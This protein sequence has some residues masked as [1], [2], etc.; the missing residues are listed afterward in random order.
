MSAFTGTQE[1]FPLP[2][3][4][5]D[6]DLLA[7]W[8]LAGWIGMQSA[9]DHLRS[10]TSLFIAL[11]HEENSLSRWFLRYV[12]AA[13]IHLDQIYES[14]QFLPA[15]LPAMK[16][17]R[18]SGK[19]PDG[20][21]AFTGSARQMVE[22][23]A[24]LLSE[25]GGVELGVRHLLAAYVYRVPQGHLEQMQKWGFDRLREGSAFVRQMVAR[26][27]VEHERWEQV[28]RTTFTAPPDLNASDPSLPPKISS[29]AADTPDGEDQLNIEDDVYAL[30]ALICSTKM[31]PPLSIGLFGDWGAGKSFFIRQ[32]RRGVAFI[33][34]NARASSY[35]QKDVPFYKNVVQIEFNA[36][37]Y[38]GG[39]L[40]ASLV[41]HILENLRLTPDEDRNLVAKRVDHL[42]QKMQ[43]AQQV[44]D[45]AKEREVKAQQELDDSQQRL[46]ELRAKHEEEVSKLKASLAQDVLATV[47]LE[48]DKVSELNKLRTELKLHEVAASAGEFLTAVNGARQSLT[49]LQALFDYVPPEQRNRFIMNS[50]LA[51]VI[52][53]LAA[54]VIGVV[55]QWFTPAIASLS[56]FAGWVSTT[57]ALGARWLT[58][59]TQTLNTELERLDRLQAHA[60]QRVA[61]EEQ[62]HKA[63]AASLEQRIA[64]AKDEILAAQVKQQEAV[65]NLQQIKAE[66]EFTTPA[67]VLADF[68]KMR[69]QSEDYRQHLGLPAVI[70]RDFESISQMVAQENGALQKM[71]TLDEEKVNEDQRINRIVLYIDDLDRCPES[72]V[73]DVLKAV[74]LLLSFPLF[75]VV[76]A[77]DARWVSHSLAQQFPGLLTPTVPVNTMAPDHGPR[78]H[79]TPNDYLEK[80][81]QIPFWLRAPDEEAVRRMMRELVLADQP[82]TAATTS[83]PSSQN[84]LPEQPGVVQPPSVF[85][86]RPHDPNA[87][88]LDIQTIELT[89]IELLAPLLAR[90][91]RTL[92]RFVNVYRLLKASLPPEEQDGF[93]DKGD[94]AIAPY[95]AVL[96]LLAIVTG[97]PDVSGAI[98]DRLLAPVDRDVS[99]QPSAVRTLLSVLA[100]PTVPDEAKPEQSLRL[101]AWL[102]KNFV[103]WQSVPSLIFL[104]WVPRVARYSYHFHHA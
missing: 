29:F 47:I 65:A 31:S 72:L 11:L 4:S 17:S 2:S 101:T 82:Q 33:A 44:V 93:L 20:K 77:V 85:K 102:D 74:H 91:P 95:Q 22:E 10:Y 14:R 59:R 41:Q 94:N 58:Q 27:P 23:A 60:Q 67:R 68:V 43:L 39:N 21:P 88:A 46:N 53:P 48:P 35:M 90:S 16:V 57:L 96:L 76:V 70:R 54:I 24:Q 34:Q 99:T 8:E 92:K 3:V 32:L 63:E 40:W 103:S 50:A 89:Y 5:L 98:L 81:F 15:N 80:I 87:T 28:H 73:V 100:Q 52:P 71:S 49:R 97:L 66:I 36:W 7:C 83:Q 37:N 6:S 55:I 26:Y 86:K 51:L 84:A 1:N 25:T 75:V 62:K 13:G 64:L 9:D 30:S 104:R 42:K 45:V 12:R 69:S 18:A 56:A 78:R 79:A 38:S 61:A 19:A